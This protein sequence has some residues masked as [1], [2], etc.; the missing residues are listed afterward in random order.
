MSWQPLGN[1]SRRDETR[2]ETENITDGMD[3]FEF[4]E[5]VHPLMERLQ[6]VLSLVG[7]AK[8]EIQQVQKTLSLTVCSFKTL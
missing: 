5:E 2:T 1:N 7:P 3:S 4:V 8:R 6:H